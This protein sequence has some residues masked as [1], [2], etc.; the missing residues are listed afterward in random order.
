MRVNATGRAAAGAAQVVRRGRVDV[1]EAARGLAEEAEPMPVEAEEPLEVEGE[2][3]GAE[4]AGEE[5][6]P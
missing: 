1:R 3:A 5:A 6:E 4:G 2:E